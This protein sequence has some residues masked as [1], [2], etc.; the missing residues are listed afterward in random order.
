M[1]AAKRLLIILRKL[2]QHRRCGDC[3]HL[4]FRRSGR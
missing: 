2:Q 1:I 4:A 3:K